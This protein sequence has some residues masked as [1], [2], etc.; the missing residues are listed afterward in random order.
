MERF[1]KTTLLLC[2]LYLASAMIINPIGCTAAAKD[3]VRL[4]LEVVIPSLFPF[5]VCSSLFISLGAANVLSRRL[6]RLMRPLF[7]VPGCGALAVVLGV[8]SGYPVGAAC[9]ADLY[10]SGHCTKTEAHRLLAFCNN[11]GPLFVLGAVGIGMLGNQYLGTILYLSH[12]TAALMT[13]LLFSRLGKNVSIP[14]LPPA[15]ASAPS[16]KNAAAALGTAVGNAADTMLKVCGFV[17]LFAVF[18]AALPS[19]PG[20]QF[21]YA[22]LEITGGLRSLLSTPLPV[23]LLLPLCAMFLSFSGVSVLMQTAGIVLPAGLSLRPYLLG[24]LVHGILSFIL[25]FL[26]LYFFPAPQPT[27]ALTAV[28][29]PVP[30]TKELFVFALVS[31]AWCAIA[32]GILA[33]AAWLF[34]RFD[35]HK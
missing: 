26:L 14:A 29:V 17:V 22:C 2:L 12:I 32:I 33:L 20:S 5:F 19:Y 25:T 4:C 23:L 1:W 10:T 31:I 7:G 6:S 21:V 18:A 16:V 24:K 30:G 13:G 8:I 35:K 34:D 3:A 28:P 27:F 15:S 11:S 9:A